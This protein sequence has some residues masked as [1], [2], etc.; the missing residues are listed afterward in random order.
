MSGTVVVGLQWGD[1]GK[2]KVIDFLAS[3]S[4]AV[5]RFNGGSNAGHSVKVAGVKYAFHLMPSGVLSGKQVMLGAGVV[6]DP[7]VLVD[8]ELSMLSQKGIIPLLTI[9][10]KAHVITPYHKLLDAYHEESFGKAAA[11]ST[12]S[13]IAPVYSDKHARVGV[14]VQ[15][16]LDDAKLREKLELARKRFFEISKA[17]YGKENIQVESCT[18]SYLKYAA[19]LKQYAGDVS[20]K[21]NLLL[22]SKKLVLFEAAQ[23]A[24]LDIDHG[25]YP[26]GTSSN[27]IAGAACTGAGVGPTK[28]KRVFGVI[29][30]YTSRVGNG[31]L[32]TELVDETGS[33]IREKGHE[34]GTTTGRPR[35]VGWLDLA[36]VKYA[37]QLNGVTDLCIV[38]LDTLAGF[39]KIKVCTG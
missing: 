31:P 36:C 20:C 27:T 9:D 16:M 6:I 10:T 1:E 28:I 3:R 22:D 24:M 2:G 15:D 33:K 23:A 35:R 38:H 7:Q 21:I 37:V 32:P 14:R 29:K 8:K 26:F 11:G 19:T 4:E 13:G 12:K 5:V 17:L 30:A 18:D 34:Y 39:E 25:L